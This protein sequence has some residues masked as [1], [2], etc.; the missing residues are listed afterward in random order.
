MTTKTLLTAECIMSALREIDAG[1]SKI[2]TNEIARV[3]ADYGKKIGIS[4]LEVRN[5][6]LNRI[7]FTDIANE[8]ICEKSKPTT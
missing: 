2:S 6:L 5:M 7:S 4:Y 3:A 8:I 1:S